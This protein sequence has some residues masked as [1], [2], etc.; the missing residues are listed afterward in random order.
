[1]R[2]TSSSARHSSRSSPRRCADPAAL[3]PLHQPVRLLLPRSVPACHASPSRIAVAALI[4]CTVLLGSAPAILGHTRRRSRRRRWPRWMVSR[5]WCMLTIQHRFLGILGTHKKL[6]HTL[7]F[8][9]GYGCRWREIRA[10]LSACSSPQSR[11]SPN[12]DASVAGVNLRGG[13]QAFRNGVATTSCETLVLGQ[14]QR[15]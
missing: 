10:A 8:C 9:C 7:T 1:M 12:R 5:I 11:R 3:A 2:P 4:P 14:G 15:P 6:T 13:K